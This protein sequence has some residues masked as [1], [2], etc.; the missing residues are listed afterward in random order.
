MCTDISF[1]ISNTIQKSLGLINV[2]FMVTF[3]AAHFP[4]Y[5]PNQK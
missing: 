5:N 1:I 3:K 4:V 2:A